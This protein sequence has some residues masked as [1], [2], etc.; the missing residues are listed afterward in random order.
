MLTD[1][2]TITPILEAN[3]LF[4][5][6]TSTF[7]F[8]SDSIEDLLGFKADDFLTGKSSLKNQIHAHDLDIAEDLF[9]VGTHGTPS[10]FNI[11]IRQANGRI[12]CIKGHYTK[13]LDASGTDTILE[14]LL[15]DAK[16][17]SQNQRQRQGRCEQSMFLNFKAM[18]ENTND[19]IYFKDNNHV[20]TGASQTLVSITDPTE[21][22]TD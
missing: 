4:S 10:S 16:S 21:H 2:D 8:V 17:L 20:F 6:N 15:Q 22:W 7:L 1:S 11:R 14:L 13:S 12:R 19:Y 18:M 3:I 9:S 5:L